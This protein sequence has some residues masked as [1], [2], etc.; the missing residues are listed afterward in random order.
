MRLSAAEILMLLNAI[1]LAH[2]GG[3]SGYATDPTI[4]KL[5]AKL[6]IMLEVARRIEEGAA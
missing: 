5:Q 2:V 3:R 4:S 6:S 1:R